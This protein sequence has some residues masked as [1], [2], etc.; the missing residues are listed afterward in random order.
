MQSG[1]MNGSLPKNCNIMQPETAT[2][3]ILYM[4]DYIYVFLFPT[5]MYI[6]VKVYKPRFLFEDFTILVWSNVTEIGT[7]GGCWRQSP[8][9][10]RDDAKCLDSQHAESQLQAEKSGIKMAYSWWVCSKKNDFIYLH[11]WDLSS[12]DEYIISTNTE[13]P[14]YLPM[15]AFWHVFAC[16]STGF[17]EVSYKMS[18]R[19]HITSPDG[20]LA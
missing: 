5:S 6:G 9:A 14:K 18:W 2:L 17:F 20:S 4:Y 11:V 19:F 8:D 13:I 3:M 15:D 7:P 1:F 10:T 12:W 16:C